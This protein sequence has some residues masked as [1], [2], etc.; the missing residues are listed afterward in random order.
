MP[1]TIEASCSKCGFE[2]SGRDTGM[3]LRLEDGSMA[4]LPHPAEI[5]HFEDH[6]TTYSEAARHWRLLQVTG[7]RCVSCGHAFD[8]FDILAD[9]GFFACL[10]GLGG[11]AVS[12]VIA[13]Q[14]VESTTNR[15]IVA[16]LMMF[17]VLHVFTFFYKQR[18][19]RAQPDLPR[20]RGCPKCE[21]HAVRP[22][23][24]LKGAKVHCPACGERA[25]IHRVAGRA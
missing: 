14:L 22:I 11:F 24:K 17:I 18:A 8:R 15:L 13:Q 21:T 25:L 7:M 4:A 3:G 10:P 12:F 6:G 1:G 5:S 16:A 9:S 19:R 23:S 2:E 20:P